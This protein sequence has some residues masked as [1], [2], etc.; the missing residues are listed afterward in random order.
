MKGGFH[1]TSHTREL[2]GTLDF[3]RTLREGYKRDT[4][5]LQVRE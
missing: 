5:K 3:E 4:G 1:T 2:F